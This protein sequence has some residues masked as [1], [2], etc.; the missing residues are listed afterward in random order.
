[1]KANNNHFPHLPEKEINKLVE[2][3]TDPNLLP[4]SQHMEEEL[5]LKILERKL[6]EG[7]IKAEMSKDGKL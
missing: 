2:E 5:L 1:M 4:T 6:K 3:L 7:V